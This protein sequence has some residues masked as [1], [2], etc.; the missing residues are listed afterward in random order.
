MRIRFR[1]GSGSSCIKL[2]H[3]SPSYYF[4]LKNA[5]NNSKHLFCFSS[6]MFPPGSGST[7]GNESRSGSTALLI[8]ITIVNVDQMMMQ[9]GADFVNNKQCSIIDD[10]TD[11]Q[12]I[13]HDSKSISLL[14]DYICWSHD[15][16]LTSSRCCGPGGRGSQP[17]GGCAA[18]GSPRGTGPPECC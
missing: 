11:L 2:R 3:L 14:Y 17:E 8:F 1:V 10:V 18:S 12:L 6:S 7:R 4:N 15:I 16:W 9:T 13:A 5:I